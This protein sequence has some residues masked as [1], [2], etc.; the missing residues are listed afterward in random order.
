MSQ[1]AMI[2]STTPVISILPYKSSAAALLLSALLG[3][4]GLLYASFWSGVIMIPIGFVVVSSKLIFP[5]LF[6]WIICC[7]LSVRKVN[8]YNAKLLQ[9]FLQKRD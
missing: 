3:P 5:I 4:I 7:V 6:L 2:T 1:S 8:V 9:Q